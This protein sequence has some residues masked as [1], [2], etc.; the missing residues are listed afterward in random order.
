[1]AD[2]QPRDRLVPVGQDEELAAVPEVAARHALGRQGVR[3]AV[4]AG[5]DAENRGELARDVVEMGFQPDAVFGGVIGGDE[6]AICDRGGDGQRQ[7]LS[8]LVIC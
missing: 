3:R 5:V 8:G 6:A 7:K 4:D 1:M 2:A